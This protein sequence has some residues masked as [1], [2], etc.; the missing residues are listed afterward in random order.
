L[1]EIY[2]VRHGEVNGNVNKKF[3]GFTDYELN[4][5]GKEKALELSKRLNQE[6]DVGYYSP[7]KRA[8]Q[9]FE[10]IRKE[11]K[12]N[13][14]FKNDGIKERNFGIFEDLNSEEITQ[15]YPE[16][17][18]NLCDNWTDYVIPEGESA[19]QA[20]IR[21]LE[22]FNQI[23]RANEGK[24]ILVVTHLGCI[25]YFLADKISD[26]ISGFWKFNIDNAKYSRLEKHHETYVLTCLNA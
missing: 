10:I 15:K 12:I 21:V 16:E 18:K 22:S 23:V 20:S 17:Y 19:S 3:V 24:K 11:N 26:N 9:T 8:Y 4:D 14:V 1:T 13:L 2:I 5:N 7:L 6:F 25:K